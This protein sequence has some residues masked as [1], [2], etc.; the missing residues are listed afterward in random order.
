MTAFRPHQI[1]PALIGDGPL[2]EG[3]TTIGPQ[4][5]TG[6]AL[7]PP[8]P[9][10]PSAPPA[11]ARTHARGALRPQPCAVKA[12]RDFAHATLGQWDADALFGDAAVVISELVTNAV[13]YGLPDGL[14]RS[15][16]IRA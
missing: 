13:R 11:A 9:P 8:A 2:G 6:A 4:G 12:A 15:A 3:L 16:Q 7:P 14:D 10:A 1:I 5:E